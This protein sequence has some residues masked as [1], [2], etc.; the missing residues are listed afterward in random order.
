LSARRN[1]RI[2][3]LLAEHSKQRRK[4]VVRLH[5]AAGLLAILIPITAAAEGTVQPKY[6]SSFDCSA[7]A[8]GSQRHACNRSHLDP[9]MGAVEQP[10]RVQPDGLVRQPQAQPLPTAKPPTIP[11]LPGTIEPG[12]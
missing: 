11:R 6:P 4:V 2:L 9:P 3:A 10:K 8:A 12:N 1:G 7:V 5:Q